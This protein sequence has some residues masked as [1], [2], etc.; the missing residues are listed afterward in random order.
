MGITL[1]AIIHKA[2]PI[3]NAGAEAYFHSV[4]KW[5]VARGHRVSASVA[6]AEGT[7]ELDGVTYVGES[8][9][10]QEP[11]DAADLLLTHLD[12]TR[13]AAWHATRLKKPLV[14]L[15]HNDAQLKFH[16]VRPHEAQLV[17]FNSR[18]IEAAVKWSGPSIVIPPP[19][20]AADYDVR[21]QQGD[22]Y[23]LVNLSEA[24][25]G[26]LFWTLA[27]AM[28]DRRFIGVLGAYGK[29]IVPKDIPPNVE[30]WENRPDPRDFYREARVILMPSSYE[31]W[32]RVPVEAAASG[33]PTIAHPTPG[34][35]ESMGWAA[36]FCS[37]YRPIDW[38]YALDM[39][40][41]S[42]TYA[43]RSRLAHARSL[44]LD[45]EPHLLALEAELEATVERGWSRPSGV[46]PKTRR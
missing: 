31:S 32:G 10:S 23:V 46:N 15:V 14:H 34:L 37:R 1:H 27:R 2:A 44:M 36:I 43:E 29:Q 42:T 3:H 24:K 33:I 12:M 25:G 22:A 16:R 11:I 26:D 19:V 20:F 7:W 6:H 39:V 13:I 5:L 21:P 17:V 38:I 28:P 45:P 41:D 8:R 9:P 18:W 40:D 4:A 35:G 30:V